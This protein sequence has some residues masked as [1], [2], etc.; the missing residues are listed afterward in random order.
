MSSSR[1]IMLTHALSRGIESILVL[2]CA[3]SQPGARR[4]LYE[5]AIHEMF[6]PTDLLPR[7][8]CDGVQGRQMDTCFTVQPQL[9]PHHRS[10]GPK[11]RFS[12]ISDH[13]DGYND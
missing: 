9:F 6:H 1:S 12:D 4:L 8:V 3:V 11:A 10:V 7:Y 13:G 2:T 5:L